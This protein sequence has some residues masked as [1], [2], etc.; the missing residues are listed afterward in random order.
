MNKLLVIITLTAALLFVTPPPPDAEAADRFGVELFYESLSPYG[1]WVEVD[2]YGYCW[3]PTDVSREWR[4]YTVGR[5]VYTDLGWTWAS[6]EPF[7][8]AVFHYGRWVNIANIGWSWV[9]DSEWAPAWVS[10]RHNDDYIG[11]A[12]LPPEA[13]F[14]VSIGFS[15]WV[16]AYYDIGPGAYCFVPYRRFCSPMIRDVVYSRDRNFNYF[17]STVNV[18]NITRREDVNYVGGPNFQTVA[19][20]SET[21]VKQLQLERQTNIDPKVALN[22]ARM[23]SKIES[24]RLVL[25]APA[26]AAT[27]AATPPKSARKLNVAK[28]ERGWEGAADPDNAR[29]LRSKVKSE[30]SLP[31]SLPP[32]PKYDKELSPSSPK[33]ETTTET[34]APELPKKKSPGETEKLIPQ[35]PAPSPEATQKPAPSETGV[36]EPPM[37]KKGEREPETLIPQVPGTSPEVVTPKSKSKTPDVP[38]ITPEQPEMQKK[39]PHK[40]E[41]RIIPHPNPPPVTRERDIIPPPQNSEK[42]E[43]LPKPKEQRQ[44]TP[45]PVIPEGKVRPNPPAPDVRKHPPG[46]EEK[47]KKKSGNN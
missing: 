20:R 1:E 35:T 21:P 26:V 10:F 30:V 12:P 6:D 42:V 45:A 47:N 33:S 43:R 17:S 29:A 25:A 5:W 9:P 40:S 19:S 15:N 31:A 14:S 41:E 34:T 2:N 44:I 38:L 16:D 37:K 27:T 28:V 39:P 11:W 4:P 46:D 24:D 13:R 8:W 36:S 18:T 3:H 23:N 32:E 22:G 7:G